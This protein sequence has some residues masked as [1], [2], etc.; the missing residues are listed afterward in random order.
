MKKKVENASS[1]SSGALFKEDIPRATKI[2]DQEVW[3][4]A[5]ISTEPV[6]KGLEYGGEEDTLMG[7]LAKRMASRDFIDKQQLGMGTKTIRP[8]KGN[9]NLADNSEEDEPPKRL[10]L[11]GIPE[12]LKTG[13]K[14]EKEHTDDPKE[15]EKIAKDHL[16]EHTKYYDKEVGLPAMEESLKKK[17]IGL[18]RHKH[19]EDII[20]QNSSDPIKF[21]KSTPGSNMA[22]QAK[23]WGNVINSESPFK[24]TSKR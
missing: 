16:A 19:K 9:T 20:A 8:G 22:D 21:T 13:I 24:K 6:R 1:A 14:I 15:A 10:N 11:A 23:Y 4:N 7:R 18:G 12:G 3:K 5:K 2:E 17:E